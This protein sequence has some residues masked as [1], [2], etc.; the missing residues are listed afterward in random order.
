MISCLSGILITNQGATP[1]FPLMGLLLPEE[2]HNLRKKFKNLMR[3]PH[4]CNLI[5]SKT[6]DVLFHIFLRMIGL[7]NLNAEREQRPTFRSTLHGI[8]GEP[9]FPRRLAPG[10]L[11]HFPFL[12]E[13]IHNGLDA[14]SQS[15]HQIVD[16]VSAQNQRW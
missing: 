7:D 6:G 12:L 15:F 14:L 11:L 10:F 13:F 2:S 16:L 1:F 8:Y 4:N 9:Q 3:R 5:C